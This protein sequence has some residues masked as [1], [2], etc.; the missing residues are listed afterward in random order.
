MLATP[1]A[2]Q[3]GLPRSDFGNFPGLAW[4]HHCPERRHSQKRRALRPVALPK[5]EATCAKRYET[6]RRLDANDPRVHEIFRI[7]V[8]VG[9]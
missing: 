9:G 2:V 8:A 6:R 4:P 3:D 7:S 5:A 1:A